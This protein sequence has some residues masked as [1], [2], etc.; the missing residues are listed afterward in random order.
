MT[1][2][3]KDEF[4]GPARPLPGAE[5]SESSSSSDDED[6]DENLLKNDPI[7]KMAMSQ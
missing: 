5:Y 7:Y 6:K 4:V 1:T 3:P 2:R